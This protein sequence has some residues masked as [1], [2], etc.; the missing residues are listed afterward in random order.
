MTNSVDPNETARYER[1]L[2]DLH[3]L[4]SNMYW[5]TGLNKFTAEGF[6]FSQH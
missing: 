2:L 6:K 5:F 3:C 4:Q 1:S